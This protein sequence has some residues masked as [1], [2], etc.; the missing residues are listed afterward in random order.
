MKPVKKIGYR[1]PN[2]KLTEQYTMSFPIEYIKKMGITPDDRN[3]EIS[4][5]EKTKVISIKKIDK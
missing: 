4:F 3:V 5:N 2:G 1:K